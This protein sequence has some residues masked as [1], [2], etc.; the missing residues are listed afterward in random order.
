MNTRVFRYNCCLGIPRLNHH[1]CRPKNFLQ[2]EL[3]Y[4]QNEHSL[5]AIDIYDLQTDIEST[6]GKV[7]KQ[8]NLMIKK[9]RDSNHS[10]R[11][12]INTI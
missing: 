8:I 4:N 10:T 11:D 9:I 5:I 2:H 12:L 1:L 6:Q 7:L 3:R